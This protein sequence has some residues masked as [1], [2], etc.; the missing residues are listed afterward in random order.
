M[1][2]HVLK[3]GHR[4]YT[5]LAGDRQ[6]IYGFR[7]IESARKCKQFLEQYRIMNGVFPR[8][9]GGSMDYGSVRPEPGFPTIHVEPLGDLQ[10]MCLV[11]GLGLIGIEK[12]DYMVRKQ[13]TDVILRAGDLGLEDEHEVNPVRVL[14]MLLE[15]DLPESP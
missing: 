6:S 15:M 9:D 8:V 4:Y 14:K 7:N 1:K 13:A 2:I 11:S 10:N 12:F 5:A 3:M